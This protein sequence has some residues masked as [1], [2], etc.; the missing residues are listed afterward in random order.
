MFVI[1]INN[2]HKKKIKKKY[3][4]SQNSRYLRD[5][6]KMHTCFIH[7]TIVNY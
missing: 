3:L 2:F 5:I 7:Y 1:V 4:Q 6:Y